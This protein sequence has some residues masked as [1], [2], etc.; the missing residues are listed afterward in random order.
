MVSNEQGALPA[1]DEW[2]KAE[3]LLADIL[4]FRV[5]RIEGA[6]EQ[7]GAIKHPDS[8]HIERVNASGRI[9]VSP[10]IESMYV[11]WQEA[12]RQRIDG[13]S[14]C[15]LAWSLYSAATGITID[16]FNGMPPGEPEE[17]LC[18]LRNDYLEQEE[19]LISELDRARSQL[20]HAGICFG[21]A[22]PARETVG[23]VCQVCGKDYSAE[24]ATS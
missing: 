11:L 13:M 17:H 1:R 6:T 19:R 24:E 12:I 23:M 21:C 8:Y 5:V 16:S 3:K 9:N 10:T 15:V 14:A 7:R 2:I 22:L 20:A 4:G 18:R